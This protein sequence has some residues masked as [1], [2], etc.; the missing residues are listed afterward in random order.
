MSTHRSLN[1]VQLS[2]AEGQ[3]EKPSDTICD[4]PKPRL[5]DSHTTSTDM[6][7]TAGSPTNAAPSEMSTPIHPLVTMGSEEALCAV[8]GWADPDWPSSHVNPVNDVPALEGVGLQSEPHMHPH[9]NDA[10]DDE[11]ET[12]ID[13]RDASDLP[14]PAIPRPA[15][16]VSSDVALYRAFGWAGPSISHRDPEDVYREWYRNFTRRVL[17][18]SHPATKRPH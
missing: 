6:N 7:V 2:M 8:F 4:K 1:P 17:G 3:E 15:N 18:Q 12:V 9:D 10:F 5:E 16:S 13:P 11:V 14:P